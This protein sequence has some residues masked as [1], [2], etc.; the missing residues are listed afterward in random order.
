VVAEMSTVYEQARASRVGF[1]D[2]PGNWWKGMLYDPE[3][4]RR[5]HTPKRAAV[6]TIDGEPAAYAI[7]RTRRGEPDAVL[8]I[9]ELIGVSDAAELAIWE[10][11]TSLDL[12]RHVESY[13]VPLDFPIMHAVIDPR[14]VLTTTEDSIWL[15]IVNLDKALTARTYSAPVD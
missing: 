7:Y 14:R 1:L 9:S 8:H 11:V 2:R 12:L 13:N 4:E 5:D 15:R 10:F 3:Y 6:L